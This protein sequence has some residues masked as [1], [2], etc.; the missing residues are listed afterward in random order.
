[1][2]QHVSANTVSVSFPKPFLDSKAI[3]AA[4]SLVA[5]DAELFGNNVAVLKPQLD[6]LGAGNSAIK[7]YQSIIMSY[8]GCFC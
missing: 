5:D 3:S 1:M 7:A 6:V 8:I 4:A 2:E